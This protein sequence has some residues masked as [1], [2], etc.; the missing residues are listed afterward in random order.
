MYGYPSWTD[1]TG[2]IDIVFP[3][4]HP[5]AGELGEEQIKA[6]RAQIATFVG[7]S[8][9]ATEGTLRNAAFSALNEVVSIVLDEGLEFAK[10]M[11]LAHLR[12][13][14]ADLNRRVATI[15]SIPA[16]YFNDLLSLRPATQQRYARIKALAIVVPDAMLELYLHSFSAELRKDVLADEQ[17]APST[18]RVLQLC[19]KLYLDISGR[20]HVNSKALAEYFHQQLWMAPP[21][22]MERIHA[23][24]LE[25]VQRDFACLADW[26]LPNLEAM[27]VHMELALRLQ[28]GCRVIADIAR[29]ETPGMCQSIVT[30]AFQEAM[31]KQRQAFDRVFHDSV[32]AALRGVSMGPAADERVRLYFQR[33]NEQ[34]QAAQARLAADRTK[35]TRGNPSLAST[36]RGN[37]P[38]DIDPVQ[39][40]SVE[41][42][43]QWIDGPMTGAAARQPI[44]RQAIVQR[45][46]LARAQ[47]V[48]PNQAANT[49]PKTRAMPV[50]DLSAND[51]NDV[52]DIV[53][54]A[55]AATAR[56]FLDDIEEMKSLATMLHAD[57]QQLQ[58]CAALQEA[59]NTL[60]R[61]PSAMDD[62]QARLL[63]TQAEDSITAL[64]NSIR[65]AQA[66]ERLQRRFAAALAATLAA[67]PRVLGKRHGG[68]IACPLKPSDWGWVAEQFHHRWLPQAKLLII[69]GERAP[70]QADQALALY[71]TG[72]SQS[73]CVFDVSVHLWRRRPGRTSPPGP[74]DE[75]HPPMNAEDWFDTYI[76]CC[77]LHVP[78]AT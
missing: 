19:E 29:N 33:S 28:T 45:E 63:L 8:I 59:L 46:R 3:A 18:T 16:N 71:V 50:P 2:D 31:E 56:F 5:L 72:S 7:K 15:D 67:E 58:A 76:P 37:A 57:P 30:L 60:A 17:R 70:L 77:V 49:P 62:V 11:V 75:D 52:N 36:P 23:D 73:Q 68:V 78:P 65:K 48:N 61:K 6:R 24:M 26:I 40:W 42:L 51:V 22:D 43:V 35:R 55:L 14:T 74:V 4:W 20:P 27:P 44:D 9:P 53:A 34:A 1:V 32:A 64:R 12:L 10:Y 41:R 38:A 13:P 21:A 66:D 39:A 47:K 54:E 25:A 69:D